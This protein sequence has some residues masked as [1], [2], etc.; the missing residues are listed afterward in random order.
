MARTILWWLALSGLWLILI[1]SVEPLEVWVGA[2]AALLAAVAGAA[3][4]R[5]VARR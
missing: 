4:G 5:A 2:A 3:A 1:S